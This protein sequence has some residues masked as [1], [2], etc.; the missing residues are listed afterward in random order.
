MF[1]HGRPDGLPRRQAPTLI[2]LREEVVDGA[3]CLVMEFES[4]KMSTEE[5][6]K[7]LP[8][9]QTFFGPG[10]V[11]SL[12][13]TEAGMDVALLSDGSGEGRGG[14]EKKDVLPPLMPGLP[15]RSQE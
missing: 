12:A 10:I 13:S 6:E 8:K 11:A 9:F 2:G 7:F 5:W 3:Y 14:G 15:A 1:K 4:P